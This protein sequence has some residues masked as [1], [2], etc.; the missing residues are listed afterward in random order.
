MVVIV[1]SRARAYIHIRPAG[2]RE[3]AM[4]SSKP[5][6]RLMIKIL[7]YLNNPNLWELWDIPY[8]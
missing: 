4:S 8:R 3:H 5:L 1:V 2:R 7:H 6:I